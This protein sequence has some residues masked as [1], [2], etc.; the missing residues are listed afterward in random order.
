MPIKISLG[1]AYHLEI[2]FG[3]VKKKKTFSMNP[4]SLLSL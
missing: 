1:N 2:T 4:V 3:N